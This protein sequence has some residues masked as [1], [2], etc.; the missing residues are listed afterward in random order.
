MQ[1]DDYRG[2]LPV[3]RGQ[4]QRLARETLRVLGE[5]TP[6]DRFAATVMLVRLRDTDPAPSRVAGSATGR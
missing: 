6:T 4:W 3:T 5:P 1:H 2:D